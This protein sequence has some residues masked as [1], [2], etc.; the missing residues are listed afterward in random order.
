MQQ[1]WHGL[2]QPRRR[3]SDGALHVPISGPGH[4]VATTVPVPAGLTAHFWAR[5]P[6]GL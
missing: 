5:P 2:G 1:A 6:M 4:L 3:G